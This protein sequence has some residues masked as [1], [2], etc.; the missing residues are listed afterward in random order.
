MW[1]YFVSQLGGT[2]SYLAPE[3]LR[4]EDPHISS[5]A[6]MWSLGALISYAANGTDHLFKTEKDVFSWRGTRSP[7]ERRR[8][9]KYPQLHQLVLSLLSVEKDKRP[10]AAQVHQDI[11]NHRERMRKI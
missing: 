7:L 5:S 6:D 10:T 9:L 1:S 4:G 3:V 11:I 2:V 8:E